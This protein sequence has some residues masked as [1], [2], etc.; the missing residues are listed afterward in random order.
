VLDGDLVAE[1]P[2]RA[3]AGVGDQRLL[4]RQF[5]LEVVLQEPGKAVSDLLCLGFR[6][7]EPEEVV[8]CLCRLPDYAESLV[9][10]L[11]RAVHLAGGSA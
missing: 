3:R 7:G 9:K 1:E 2:R 8:I 10:V 11:A 6:S 4:L 5:Q